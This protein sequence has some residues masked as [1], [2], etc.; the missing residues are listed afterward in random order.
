ME[1]FGLPLKENGFI[2]ITR[3]G[4]EI[5]WRMERV[6]CGWIVWGF[7]KG[8]VD[9]VPVFRIEAP[10]KVLAG[11]WQSWSSFR[12]VTLGKGWT[13]RGKGKFY[14]RGPD[15]DLE[16][17]ISDYLVAGRN[18][19]AGFLSS[20]IAHGFFTSSGG[21]LTAWLDYFDSNFDRWIPLE[22]F[23][24][25]N[26]NDVETLLEVYASLVSKENSVSFNRRA[27][28]GWSSWYQYFDSLTWQDVLNSLEMA[29]SLPIGTFQI[30]DGYERDIGDWLDVK[31][32]FP[33]LDEIARKIR[34]KGFIPGIWISPFIVSASS[35]IFQRHRDWVVKEAGRPKVVFNHWGRDIYALDLSNYE[36]VEWL[37][38]LFKDL[39]NM[40]FGMFKLD[41]LF[42]GAAEGGRKEAI[43]PMQAFRKGLEVIRKATK[44]AFLLGCG[45]PLIATA[46]FVDAM[47]VGPDVAPFWESGEGESSPSAKNALR[48]SLTRNFFHGRLWNND[49]DCLLLREREI[50]LSR[51]QR[52]ILV[53]SAALLNGVIFVS[54]DLELWGKHSR[55]AFE[56]VLK[57]RGG[58]S[59][60]KGIFE[61]GEVYEIEAFGTGMGNIR[62]KIDLSSGSYELFGED[63]RALKE[64]KV[65]KEDGRIF[66][67]YEGWD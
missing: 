42:A 14:E 8:K 15:G 39:R 29:K 50:S 34:D 31:D 23:V 35:K 13:E 5:R 22:P 2:E 4:F 54:D 19:V 37:G 26:G 24:F 45:A 47:R 32:G 20:K 51:S 57:L 38:G 64:R 53:F 7:V 62:M 25:L 59:R 3:E 67:F 48:N 65:A 16:G 60:V 6:C 58:R 10:E 63:Y 43:T 66:S 44:G 9:K 61:E 18:W 40:G 17:W 52:E 11:G 28:L 1:I 27:P 46:G 49:P 55:E 30:D 36:V 41:F 21:I 56:K 33:P 12:V